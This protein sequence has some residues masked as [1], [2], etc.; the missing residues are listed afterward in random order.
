MISETNC[1]AVPRIL[2]QNVHHGTPHASPESRNIAARCRI[3]AYGVCATAAAAP[4]AVR[5][6]WQQL[7]PIAVQLSA[8]RCCRRRCIARIGEVT[9]GVARSA[10]GQIKSFGSALLSF[11]SRVQCA[12][13]GFSDCR[14]QRI[15]VFTRVRLLTE[16]GYTFKQL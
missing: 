8:L 4:A 9:S 15:L 10:L 2:S 1:R 6:C 7:L 5:S 13:S 16:Q 3:T 12:C 14:W 11:M